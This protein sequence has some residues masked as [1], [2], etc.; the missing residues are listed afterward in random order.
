[1]MELH[2]GRLT[3]TSTAQQGTT[4]ELRFPAARVVR[5]ADP[6]HLASAAF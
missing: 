6:P 2:G 3:I 4:V 1:M 5:H